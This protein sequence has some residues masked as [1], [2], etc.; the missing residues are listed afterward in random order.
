[1]G[2]FVA[3]LLDDRQH[4]EQAYRACFGL[5]RLG[6]KFTNER[7]NAACLR[8]L[9]LGARRLKNVKNILERGLDKEA[10]PDTEPTRSAGHHENVRG[11][12]YYLSQLDLFSDN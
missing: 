6:K 8:A 12:A 11:A 5:M 3:V 4:P 1:V 9:E 10:P 7:L 2:E